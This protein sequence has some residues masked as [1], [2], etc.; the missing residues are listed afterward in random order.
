MFGIRY[1]KAPPTVHV[2][3]YVQGKIRRSGVG[4]SFVYFA[5]SAIIVKV[6]LTSVAVPFA[7]AEMTADFQDVTVQGELTYRVKDPQRVAAILDFSVDAFGRYRSDDPTKLSERL[8]HPAQTLTRAFTQQRKLRDVLLSSAAL[9]EHVFAGLQGSPQVEM[10]GVEVLE[11]S[12]LSIKPAPDMNKAI[13]ADARESLLR[14]ADEAIYARRNASVEL[15]RQIK[16]NELNTEVAVA[17]KRRHVRETEMAGAIAVEE[18]RATLVDHRAAN[19]KKEADA[20]GYA[21]KSTVDALKDADWRTLLAASGG[22]DARSNIALAF[23]ELAEN[24]GKIGTLNITPDLLTTLLDDRNEQGPETSPNEAGAAQH[25]RR[26]AR[27][28]A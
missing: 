20:R 9:V 15:E 27:D 7:F 3:H 6:P 17:Q 11:F 26:Q 1:L 12:V 14:T 28:K 2:F 19:E 10:L 21:L 8:I 23:R 24:A 5:P 13:Q 4:L 18:Q 22:M 16:E 25:H